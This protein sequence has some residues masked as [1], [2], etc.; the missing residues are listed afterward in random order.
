MASRAAYYL[1]LCGYRVS[2]VNPARIKAYAASRLKR[3]K[4]DKTDALLI[5]E[6]LPKGKTGLWSPA[7]PAFKT[8]KAWVHAF[9]ALMAIKQHGTQSSGVQRQ[10]TAGGCHLV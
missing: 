8:L 2:V 9:D 4:T 5:A 1:Y 7:E 3:N 6:I 10:R